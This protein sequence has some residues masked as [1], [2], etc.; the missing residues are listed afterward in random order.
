MKFYI[1]EKEL[2]E[3]LIENET[4]KTRDE[5]KRNITRLLVEAG[6]AV[7]KEGPTDKPGDGKERIIHPKRKGRRKTFSPLPTLPFP[8]VTRFEI[9]TPKPKMDIRLADNEL[10]LVETDADAEFDTRCRIAIRW[11]PDCLEL[12]AKGPLRGGRIRWRLRPQQGAQ[13]GQTGEITAT[14]TKMDG[15]QL[16]DKVEFEVLEPLKQKTKEAKGQAPPFEVIGIDPDNDPEKWSDVW[17]NMPE[18]ADYGIKSSVA[19]KPRNI[20]GTIYIYYSKIF[21]PFAQQL[22]NIKLGSTALAEMFVMNYETWI[23]YHGILQIDN[24]ANDSD[25]EK[26]EQM[27][28]EERV[29][30]AKMQIKQ[31]VEAAKLLRQTMRNVARED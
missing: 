3:K 13:V 29:R 4:T 1:I 25:Y 19:Y 20:A 23:G 17:D 12:A 7:K 26:K 24:N 9:V 15:T 22:E 18:D 30:V 11:E 28:E 2:T 10:V 16:S 21:Q 8:E 27:F 31:A 5:V 14:L 6:Y